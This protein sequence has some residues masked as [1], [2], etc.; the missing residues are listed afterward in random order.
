ML[1]VM[2][3]EK[4]D[5]MMVSDLVLKTVSLWVRLKA[6]MRDEETGRKTAYSLA[7]D[8]ILKTVRLLV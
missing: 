4:M 5:R 3:D 7:S 1:L 8:L 2:L 6:E